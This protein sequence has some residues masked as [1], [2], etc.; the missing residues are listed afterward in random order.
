MEDPAIR[1]RLDPLVKRLFEKA[2]RRSQ[3]M[4]DLLERT[5]HGGDPRMIIRAATMFQSFFRRQEGMFRYAWQEYRASDHGIEAKSRYI[6]KFINTAVVLYALNRLLTAA[7]NR[8]RGIRGPQEPKTLERKAVEEV[9]D[10]IA[11][12][13]RWAPGIGLATSSFA[14]TVKMGLKAWRAPTGRN[15]VRIPLVD[16]GNQSVGGMINAALA[17]V[18]ALEGERYKQGSRI[19]EK[20]W[21]HSAELATQQILTATGRFTGIPLE[22]LV[23]VQKTIERWQRGQK[24]A[25]MSHSCWGALRYWKVPEELWIYVPRNNEG[26]STLKEAKKAL[27]EGWIST[28]Q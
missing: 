20:K 14:W 4:W 8:I 23:D 21:K 9:F 1:E 3:P 19:Y 18:Q 24:P 22:A 25:H 17:F 6:L 11:F 7:W 16:T 13:F 12:N 15:L 5:M 28:G 27:E 10:I 2:A 26:K